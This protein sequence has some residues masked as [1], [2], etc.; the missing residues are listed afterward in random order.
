MAHHGR[1]ALLRVPPEG[2]QAGA[3]MLDVG[4][5]IADE[6]HHQRGRGL[7]IRQP[8]HFSVHIGQPEVRGGGPQRQHG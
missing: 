7:K 3:D 5:M 1:P 4:A 8:G 6:Q 2:G